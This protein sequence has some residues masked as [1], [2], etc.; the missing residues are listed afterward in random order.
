MKVCRWCLSVGTLIVFLQLHN[1][2]LVPNN[3]TQ[4]RIS[5]N[6]I[7]VQEF[8]TI[9]RLINFL[10]QYAAIIFCIYVLCSTINTWNNYVCCW[11]KSSQAIWSHHANVHQQYMQKQ[12][13]QKPPPDMKS[14]SAGYRTWDVCW[15]REAHAHCLTW[16]LLLRCVCL[17]PSESVCLTPERM[18]LVIIR[19]Y[20]RKWRARPD[21]LHLA[22]GPAECEN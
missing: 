22:C 13:Q 6:R 21:A 3:E 11:H 19:R 5:L 10:G 9:K 20:G 1:S 14:L 4:S 8:H 18:F 16:D 17:L 2:P 7:C 12:N 15:A